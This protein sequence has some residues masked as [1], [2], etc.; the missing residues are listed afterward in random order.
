MIILLNGSINSGKSTVAK[1]LYKSL[2]TSAL[3]EIDS[4]H[5][6][7][8]WMPID[9]AVPLNL[10]NALSVIRNFSKH[11]I[12][13][14]VPYPLS[15]K[16][17]GYFKNG[18]KDLN[19]PV[20]VFTLAPT[21]EKALTNRGSR[22]LDEWEKERIKYHYKIGIPTPTFGEI[23]DNS[24]QTPEQTAKYILDKIHELQSKS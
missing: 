16:N 18:L 11:N 21:L 1:L 2:T 12:H 15:Q 5:Q 10:E 22:I 7:I 17:Y 6:M 19:I 4:F 9:Q 14:I 13:T 3:L 8:E 23:I 24:E 20:A